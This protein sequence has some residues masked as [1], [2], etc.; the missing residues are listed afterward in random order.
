M[1][2]YIGPDSM[3]PT[4]KDWKDFV[5][6][7]KW[8]FGKGEK[9]QFDRWTYWEKFDYFAVFWGVAVIG[10]TGLL[11][12]Y[13]AFFTRFVPRCVVNVATSIQSEELSMQS[14]SAGARESRGASNSSHENVLHR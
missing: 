14:A 9:P 11:L 1:M 6:H 13:P 10:G 4:W 3:M 12:W 2:L 7:N 5:A 8:F